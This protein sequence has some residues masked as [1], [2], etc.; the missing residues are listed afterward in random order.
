MSLGSPTQIAKQFLMTHRDM[1]QTV[2]MQCRVLHSHCQHNAP[3]SDTEY[4]SSLNIVNFK[5]QKQKKNIHA[6]TLEH[7]GRGC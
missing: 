3:I 7:K 6:Y 2:I 4:S 5:K 1:K